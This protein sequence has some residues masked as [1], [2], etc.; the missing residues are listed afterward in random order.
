M[1]KPSI[2]PE[3]WIVSL[4]DVKR[5]YISMWK[6][7]FKWAFLGGIGF[8]LYFGQWEV[9]YK[10]EA[11]F[12][13]AAERSNTDH[14]FKEL[15]GGISH[16]SQ[17]QATSL[18][19]SNQVLKPLA[20]KLGLQIQPA[21]FDWR[22]V[23]LL[24]RYKDTWRA[25]KGLELTDED[26]FVFENVRYEGKGTGFSLKFSSEHEF[27]IYE[28]KK[29][30]GKGKIGE[31]CIVEDVAFTLARA[32]KKVKFG[33][34]YPFSVAPWIASV[35]FIQGRIKIKADK[36]NASI[37]IIS[38]VHRDR[39][40]AVQMVN[41]LM[42]EFQAYLKR[43]YDSIAKNQIA[44]LEGKQEQ[45]FG[46][47]DELFN[48]HI[49]YLSKNLSENGF[50]GLEQE[51][52]NLL[53]PH[54]QMHTKLLAL[55]VELKRLGEM[56][57]EGKIVAIAEDG[58]FSSAFNQVNKQ[59]QDLKQ[60][61]DLIEL[62]LSQATEP[63]LQ[64][65]K[66]ELKEVR[67]ARFS[68]ETMIKELDHSGEI[69]S[70]DLNPALARWANNLVDPEE[71]EDFAEYLENYAR[72]LGMREKMLQERFFYGK[73]APAELE[74]IDLASAR[75]LFLQ[76]NAKLDGAEANL[77]HYAQLKKEIV[78]PH[79][80][81]APLSS[82]LHD[83][84]SQKIIADAGQLEVQLK[85]EKH[86]SAKEADRWKE[87]IALQRKILS[88]HL[89]QLANVEELN[90]EL[91]REKMSGLQRL[92]LDCIN[93]QISVLHG[94]AIDAIKE[95]KRSLLIEREVLGKKMEE[96]RASLAAVLPEKWRFEKWLGIKTAMVNKVME[97][98]TEVVESKSLTSQLHHVESK[99]LD[100]ALVPSA[101][102]PPHL[103]RM[104]YIGAF[105]LPFLIFSFAFIKRLVRGFPVSHE[106][107]K[108]LKFPLLG[109]ISPFCDG[110]LT[111]PPTGPDLELLRNMGLFS[112]G[113]RVVG[114]ISGKGPDYSYAFA[115][116]MARRQ[117]RSII[118]R[119]DFQGVSRKEDEPG[120]LQVWKGEDPCI[121]KG[122][123]FDMITAGGYTPFGTEIIQSNQFE[124]L[125]AF[126]A[127]KYD[128]VF[129]LFK[130]P[131]AAAES[132]AALRL[133]DKAIVTACG[134]Q[135]EELTP[136][137]HWGYDGDNCR[138]TFITSA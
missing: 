98:V 23:Q 8:Y 94:Q 81:L 47:M 79:F 26:R 65:R 121:R 88:E 30:I 109:A 12:K 129:L 76:Y 40:L 116:N 87:E 73:E 27:S 57:K 123:D 48:Q 93:Q 117:I 32:P 35:G 56:E 90:A 14:F 5:L 102:Q 22:I 133:C 106:K 51:T 54:H 43:E 42:A 49:D 75:S 17:P 137:V 52:Q 126:L 107:L 19:K 2:D 31:P 29:E 128:R 78:N 100:L 95:R 55:D 60:Q 13:E 119:C 18:M 112:E 46:K 69:V 104:A 64:A 4:L 70:C 21:F 68:V 44:Y 34:N 37:L 16:T 83:S 89:D 111:S 20:E 50:A 113:A 136:F 10:A 125:I 108:A 84:L 33:K 63:T 15:I 74:G 25:E 97:T 62:T 124:E 77:R 7:L 114:L 6:K 118:V 53:A 71:K 85:D 115:E 41:G 131:L 36:D 24:K 3:E 138:I 80:D 132:R 105:A 120:I 110:K 103:N 101:P 72:L 130:S 92:S 122:S 59:I 134:E 91:L 96:L 86:H 9:V 99:P 11:S 127:R 38:G 28:N 66:S 61:R 45:V 1:E 39:Y 135:I 58:P 82:V 67:K